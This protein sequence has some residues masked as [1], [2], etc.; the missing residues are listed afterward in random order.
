VIE[1]RETLTQQSTS[2]PYRGGL[3]AHAR[4]FG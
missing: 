1:L 4:S 3:A 2:T